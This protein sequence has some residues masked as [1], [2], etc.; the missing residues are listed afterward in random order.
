[1]AVTSDNIA[2]ELGRPAPAIGGLEDRQWVSW[3]ARAR[4]QIA[5]RLGDLEALDQETLDDVVILAVAEHV[6]RPDDATQ[7]E[8]AVDDG[9]VSRR[10]SS[11]NGQITIRD[12]W[13]N[14]LS[15]G[16]VR[17]TATTIKVGIGN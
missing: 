14:R 9:R 2:T 5:E 11:G 15:P 16:S 7:V 10:Y 13:W 1:M 8:V 12:E 4:K 17:R 3:I 6:R